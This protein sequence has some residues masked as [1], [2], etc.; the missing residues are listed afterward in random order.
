[1]ARQST[2]QKKTV[3]R[4]MHEY[5]HG[6]LKTSRGKK[7]KSRRQAVAIALHEAGAS[8][9]ESRRENEKTL[10]RTKR[11]ERRGDTAKARTEGGGRRRSTGTKRRG[12]TKTR[13][14]LYAEARR[15]G[16]PGR[17]RMN[18]QQL[19]RALRR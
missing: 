8:K 17:S 12:A 15:R 3:K 6:E 7:V 5:K 14:E 4:V 11:R 2:P 9:Y 18:K 1:M 13:A 16:I 10:R 19:E